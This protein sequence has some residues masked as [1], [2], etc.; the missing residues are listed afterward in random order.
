[1]KKLLII[2]PAILLCLTAC[3]GKEGSVKCTL[4]SKDAV[5][6]YSLA[7]TYTINYKGELVESVDTVE[8]IV[9]EEKTILDTY[10]TTL[11][12]TYSKMQKTYGGYDYKIT[13]DK[14]KLTSKVTIDYNKMDI[15]QFVKDQPALKNFVKN[16]KLTVEG[17]QSM[18]ETMGATCK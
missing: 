9:T 1:M 11:N 16:S 6:N 7:A 12:D 13:K 18:Y 2:V 3:G 8:E 15:D 10:E 5:N 14:D 4:E 17:I